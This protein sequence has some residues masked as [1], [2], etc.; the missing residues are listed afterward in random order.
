VPDVRNDI[1][2]VY[3]RRL[4]ATG[5]QYWIERIIHKLNRWV[6]VPITG[7]EWCFQSRLPLVHSEKG[8]LVSKNKP[9]DFCR[10]PAEMV[11]AIN[12]H[13]NCRL[14]EKFGLHI[15]EIVEALQHPERFR[16]ARKLTSTFPPIQPLNF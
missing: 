5:L 8:R 4:P 15:V 1:G 9:V 6:N 3:L 7:H 11:N 12:E 16:G 14:S 10:G 13:R 2:P